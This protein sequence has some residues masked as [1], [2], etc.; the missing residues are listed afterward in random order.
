M[1]DTFDEL[2]IIASDSRGLNAA[3]RERLK[4]AAEEM[5]WLHQMLVDTQQALIVS[6]QHRIALNERLLDYAKREP[7][8]FPK[9]SSGWMAVTM[10]QQDAGP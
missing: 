7:N 3:D 5:E 9:L 10:T 6:Q 2:R 8:V 1:T 4:C